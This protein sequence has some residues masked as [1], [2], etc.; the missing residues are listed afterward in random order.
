MV[1][2]PASRGNAPNRS[3]ASR[4]TCP[5]T[6]APAHERRPAVRRRPNRKPQDRGSTMSSS[7]R[8]RALV[9]DDEDLARHLIREYLQGH[10][11]VEVVGECENGL[12]AVRQIGALNPDL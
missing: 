5:S 10:A 9:V 3:S 7:P 8:L 12:D 6:R 4:S 1:P 2:A 11:D